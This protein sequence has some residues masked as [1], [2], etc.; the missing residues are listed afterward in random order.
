MPPLC[1]SDSSA[2]EIIADGAQR[3][4]DTH[5]DDGQ[6]Q[7]SATALDAHKHVF[8]RVLTLSLDAIIWLFGAGDR[9]DQGLR[10]EICEVREG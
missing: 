2:R 5:V 4:R 6:L 8:V 3:W 7:V 1:P 10:C 9:D